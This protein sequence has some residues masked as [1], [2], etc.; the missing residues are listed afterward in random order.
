MVTVMSEKSKAVKRKKN[1]QETRRRLLKTAIRLFSKKGFHG[2][3]VDEIVAASKVN[4]RMV[5]HYFG[6]KEDLYREALL[7]V[8]G[9]LEIQE[10][11]V[12]EAAD[13]P[14]EVLRQVI[15][16]YFHFHS[17]NPEFVRLLLWENLNNGKAIAKAKRLLSKHPAL[18]G[19]QKVV[20]RGI[21]QGVFRPD[22][23]VRQLLLNIIGLSFIYHSNRYTLSQA[24][25]MNLAS[26][27]VQQEGSE[28]AIR[29]VLEG[30]Q[31]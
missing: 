14:E 6:S 29:L 16:N 26:R 7:E 2:V 12:M 27:E 18:T 30:I 21:E 17:N 23:D 1:P 22:I 4:K 5:Y 11:K 8:Y 20:E 25:S 24:L 9:K 3:S 15:A 31:A 19:L 13:D 28:A 10:I